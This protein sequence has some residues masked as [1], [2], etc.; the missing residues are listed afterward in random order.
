VLSTCKYCRSSLVG[1]PTS[2]REIKNYST[3]KGDQYSVVLID[4][5][6]S[7]CKKINTLKKNFLTYKAERVDTKT[8]NRISGS[9]S[10]SL[11][12]LIDEQL[13]IYQ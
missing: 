9:T 1:S 2:H 13:K 11:Q 7:N 8:G 5:N 10:Y 3:T 4:I 12:N 6:C